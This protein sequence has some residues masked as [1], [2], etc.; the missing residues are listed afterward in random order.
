MR[1]IAAASA[2]RR[3]SMAAVTVE[4]AG[5]GLA[6][7]GLRVVRLTMF[8]AYEMSA[9]TARGRLRVTTERPV[10]LIEVAMMVSVSSMGHCQ[11]P[12]GQCIWS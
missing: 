12:F 6:K 2:A 9:G 5:A 8:S 7:D 10:D 3:S 4:S 11:S 1:E